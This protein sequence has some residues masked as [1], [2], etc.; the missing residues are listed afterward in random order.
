MR[1]TARSLL[2]PPLI[3]PVAPA[4]SRVFPASSMD[5]PVHEK[6]SVTVM[7]PVPRRM[8]PLWVSVAKL[9]LALK[10]TVPLERFKA[11]PLVRT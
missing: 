5:P 4:A 9:W 6:E 11:G 10:R 1:F 7:V 8:P 2:L 3:V